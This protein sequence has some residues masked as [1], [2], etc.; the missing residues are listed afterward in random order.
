[1]NKYMAWLPALMILGTVIYQPVKKVNETKTVSK[2]ISFSVYKGSK[3]ASGIY[4]NTSAQV[5]I[6]VEKVNNRGERS[7]VWD[8]TLDA[9]L[10]KQYPAAAQA[11]SQQITV[12][13]VNEKKEHLEVKYILT[14]NSKGS[15]LQMQDD[16]VVS[17]KASKVNISI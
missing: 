1:M 11:L 8:T 14:Y 10:L 16:M 17:E 12:S 2:S 13:N 15:E 6:V 7:T 5:Q 4:D 3:Y 9:K